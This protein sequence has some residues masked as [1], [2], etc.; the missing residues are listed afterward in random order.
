[1]ANLIPKLRE[2]RMMP[3]VGNDVPAVTDLIFVLAGRQARKVYGLQL[4]RNG[5]SRHILLSTG[6]FEIRRFAELGLPVWPQLCAARS[7]TP[8]NLRHFFVMYDDSGWWVERIPLSHFGTF[9]E[10]SALR[11][12]LIQFPRQRSLLIVSDGFHLRRV[13][14]CCCRLLP[15]RITVRYI[16]VPEEVGARIRFWHAFSQWS[17]EGIKILVY[18]AIL[19]IGSRRSRVARK[20]QSED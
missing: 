16:A 2:S 12:L 18:F 1:M 3:E 5:L 11:D 14:M 7:R 13:Q 9:S 10:I 6:R 4:W 17:L 19:V 8:P 20:D 15:K